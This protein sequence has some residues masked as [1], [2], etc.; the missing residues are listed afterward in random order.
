MLKAMF[1][2]VVVC[3]LLLAL[4]LATHPSPIDPE[5]FHPPEPRPMEGPLARI[6]LLRQGKKWSTDPYVGPEGPLVEAGPKLTAGMLGGAI[7]ELTPGGKPRELA[8]TGGR[9]LALARDAQ[10]RIVIADADKGLLRIEPGGQLTTLA[11]AADG[12]PFGFVNDLAVASDGG[13]YFDDSSDVWH[14]K[15]FPL[16]VL[17]GRPRGR[18]LRWD[19]SGNVKLLADHLYF[20]NGVALTPGEDALLFAESTRYRVSKLH[21]KGP[22]AGQV[23]VFC[24]NLPG[25]PD[26]IRMSPR[27]TLW[28]AIFSLRDPMLDTVAP[29]PFVRGLVAR[30]PRRLWE[31]PAPYGMALE[32]GADGNILRTLQDP[33]G[34]FFPEVTSAVEIGGQ[35]WLGSVR[36]PQYAAIPLAP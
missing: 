24:D 26:N 33:G 13:I 22:R 36:R 7:V 25:F 11:T 1:G 31:D 9:P 21:L 35:L 16:E 4:Y 17:E 12:R 30:L 8:N 6:E 28:V 3:V 14:I 29:Y 18:V 27:G 15:D 34:A 2:A 10:G 20:P 32:L 5:A 19:P 23:E